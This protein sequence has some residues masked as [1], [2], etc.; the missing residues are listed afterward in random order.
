ML[1]SLARFG[2]GIER[3]A[4]MIREHQE[5]QSI[6][7]L[8]FLKHYSDLAKGLP[9]FPRSRKSGGEKVPPSSAS[10]ADDGDTPDALR[11]Q[12]LLA[13]LRYFH[14]QLICDFQSL[15]QEFIKEQIA[16]HREAANTWES[17]VPDFEGLVDAPIQ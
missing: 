1:M 17:L 7:L 11:E 2:S 4:S 9:S 13:E 12:I 6:T 3:I 10:S 16:F 14:E 15:I 8:E 5:Q